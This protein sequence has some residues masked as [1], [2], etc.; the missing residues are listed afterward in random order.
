[1]NKEFIF[2]ISCHCDTKE[3]EQV[4]IDNINFI[5]S[6]GHKTAV[7]SSVPF[8]KE[9]QSLSDYSFITDENPMTQWPSRSFIMWKE[10]LLHDK[11]YRMTVSQPYYGWAGFLH[12]KRLGEIMMSY[13]Y[14]DFVFI[15]YDLEFDESHLTDIYNE[16]E[17]IVFPT[18]NGEH[19]REQGLFLYYMNKKT[20]ID[21]ISLMNHEVFLSKNWGIS[22]Y[23]SEKIFKPLGFNTSKKYVN[24]KIRFFDYDPLF[25]HSNN[26]KLNFFISSPY[27]NTENTKLFFYNNGVGTIKVYCNEELI[28][29]DYKH[30]LHLLDLGMTKDNIYELF[31]IVDNEPMDVLTILSKINHTTIEVR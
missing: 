24:D 30:K 25:N 21:F 6:N 18:K 17:K 31:I 27:N 3:K 4:L 22:K 8:S 2:C 16:P 1:M 19:V 14:E 11:T 15:V 7:M 20:L 26:K 13:G 29:D 5:Q 12:T 9:V 10:W 28:Y 23:V